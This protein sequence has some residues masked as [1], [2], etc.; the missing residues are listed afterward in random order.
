MK[1]RI[2]PRLEALEARALLSAGDLDL[3]FGGTG[4]VTTQV[5]I[6]WSQAYAV[7]VQPDLKVVTA[8]WAYGQSHKTA[9][10]AIG[11][12]RYNPDGS[13]DPSYGS[14]GIALPATPEQLLT[15]P[16]VLALQGDGKILVA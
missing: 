3:T 16:A 12:V 7:A 5:R 8:G 10:S 1:M 14:G 6:S 11:L 2:R 4:K 15:G 9:Y 13:L